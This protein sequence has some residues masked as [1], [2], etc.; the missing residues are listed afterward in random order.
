MSLAAYVTPF[1]SPIISAGVAFA[2]LYI[3]YVRDKRKAE[4]GDEK[5]WRDGRLA[6]EKTLGER[7]TA[8]EKARVKWELENAGDVAHIVGLLKELGETQ[9]L[10][11]GIAT[12]SQHH[13]TDIANLNT[14]QNDLQNQ[15]NQFLINHAR[16]S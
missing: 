15:I 11:S 12:T 7:I 5:T 16:P 10:L 4:N 2:I 8:E 13:S 6:A 3:N 9:R 1:I 14:R